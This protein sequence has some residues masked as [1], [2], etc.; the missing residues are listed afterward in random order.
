MTTDEWI[1]RADTVFNQL[2]HDL[3][4]AHYVVIPAEYR[5]MLDSRFDRVKTEI[6]HLYLNSPVRKL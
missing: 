3:E 4:F 1:D 6:L 5:E 2:V